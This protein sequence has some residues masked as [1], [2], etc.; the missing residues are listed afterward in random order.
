MANEKRSRTEIVKNHFQKSL[1]GMASAMDKYMDLVK[2]INNTKRSKHEQW[3]A[4]SFT[5]V[6]MIG[7]GLMVGG[8][9]L[10]AMGFNTGQGFILS[11]M[12]AAVVAGL[13]FAICAF[14][15]IREE[16]E[17]TKKDNA[18]LLKVLVSGETFQNGQD[19][20]SIVKENITKHPK[21]MED[22]MVSLLDVLQFNHDIAHKI[23]MA[24]E[25]QDPNNIKNFDPSN[26][27][28]IKN[29]LEFINKPENSKLKTEIITAMSEQLK[30]LD[31]KN[32]FKQD[33]DALYYLA[34]SEVIKHI[35]SKETFQDKIEKMDSPLN[36]ITYENTDQLNAS[37][38][39]SAA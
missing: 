22:I 25:I 17:I 11:A 27:D 12:I 24:L 18:D 23:H 14:L 7:L 15:T 19:V 30:D 10:L 37:Q 2:R 28:Y 3:L 35:T 13:L 1:R 39:K 38:T 26:K 16:K 4:K 5:I 21:M 9:A 36:K 34:K 31:L 6:N 33:K 32:L 20:N 8:F 29:I